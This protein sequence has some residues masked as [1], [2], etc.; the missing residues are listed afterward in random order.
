MPDD[1][2]QTSGVDTVVTQ[3]KAYREILRLA[4]E[5][6]ADLIVLG[7]HGRNAVDRLVFGSTTEHVVRRGTC[8]VL[9][10]PAPAQPR[11]EDEHVRST[12]VPA[13]RA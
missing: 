11:T 13:S 4:S 12:T 8:P 7:V 1:L 2:A 10:V 3:G 6:D 5:R 9:T